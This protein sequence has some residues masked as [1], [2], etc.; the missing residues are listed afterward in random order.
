MKIK[1]TVNVI[2]PVKNCEKFVGRCIESILKQTRRPEKILVVDDKS[3]DNSLNIILKYA[4]KYPSMITVIMGEGRGPSAARQKALK[5]A[6]GKYIAFLDADDFYHRTTIENQLKHINK[7]GAVCG[8]MI[9]ILPDGTYVEE[10]YPKNDFLIT[11]SKLMK[12]N[13]VLMSSIMIKKELLDLVGGFDEKI[14]P[15]S[16]EDYDLHLRLTKHTN[17]LFSKDIVIYYQTYGE[18]NSSELFLRSKWKAIVWRKHNFIKIGEIIKIIVRAI[19][20]VLSLPINL[21]RKKFLKTNC[22]LFKNKYLYILYGYILG[23]FEGYR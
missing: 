9:K 4:E 11:H 5:I 13:Y 19:L 14:V 1:E 20:N 10:K 2:I 12:Q 22:A 18:R 21:I 15:P 17:Y 6:N 16:V 8:R 23:L 3:N 7:T